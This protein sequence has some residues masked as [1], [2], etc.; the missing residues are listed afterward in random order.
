VDFVEDEDFRAC[1]HRAEAHGFDISRIAFDAVVGRCVHLGHVGMAIGEDGHADSSTRRRAQ[2]W[3]AIAVHAGAVQC[4]GDD[5]GGGGFATPRTRVSMKAWATRPRAKAL[6]NTRTIASWPIRSA[7]VVG[8][9]CGR[10]RD[11]PE[12]AASTAGAGAAAEDVTEQS[13]TFRDRIRAIIFRR[14]IVLEQA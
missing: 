13:R 2:R 1:L 5:A 4:A 9:I 3:G 6:R 12:P 7:N 8:D 11:R 14:L 10:E